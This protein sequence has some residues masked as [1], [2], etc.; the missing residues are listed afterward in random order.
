MDALDLV[1]GLVSGGHPAGGGLVFEWSWVWWCLPLPLLIHWLPASYAWRGA[2]LVPFYQRVGELRTGVAHSASQL[3]RQLF[4]WLLWLLLVSSASKPVWVGEPIQLSTQGRDLMVAVDISGSM[5]ARDMRH[6]G[7]W[8]RRIS[9]VKSVVGDFIKRRAGDRM[10][11][12]LFGEVPYLQVPLSFDLETVH[13]LLLEAEL[14]FAGQKT[15]IGDAIGL[16]VKRLHQRP[17]EHKVLILLTDG[18]NNTGRIDPVRGA[19]LA[20]EEGIR[21]YTIGV[22]ADAVPS[23]FLSSR[24]RAN[25]DLDERTLKRIAAISGGAYY[26]ARDPASLSEAYRVLDRLEPVQQEEELFRPRA[27]LYH[28]PLAAAL[29]A[30]ML[31]AALLLVRQYWIAERP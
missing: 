25:R 3:G 14:G 29:V 5:D 31:L 6:S 11:L 30:S 4:L 9:A 20:A 28:V 26:R 21:I 19:E 15:A 24:R 10:G 27:D 22:G 23:G 18:A 12:I 16:A 8:A 2:L 13:T 7:G 17:T 1:S